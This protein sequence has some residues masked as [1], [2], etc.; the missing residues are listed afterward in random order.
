MLVKA[1]GRARYAY[2][3]WT[4]FSN[5]GDEAIREAISGVLAGAHHLDVPVN[6]TQLLRTISAGELLPLQGRRLVLG[7]GTIIGRSNWRRMVRVAR[8]LTSRLPAL[9]IG[10]GVEDPSFQGLN[11]FS[12]GGELAKW[13]EPLRHFDEICVRGPRSASLLRGVGIDATVVGDP[14]LLLAPTGPPAAP[15]ALVITLGYGDDLLG[16]DQASVVDAVV[17]AVRSYADEGVVVRFVVVAPRDSAWAEECCGRIRGAE[18]VAVKRP[19]EWFTAVADARVVVAQR[20]HAAVL[21]AGAGVPVVAL[22]YQPK[23]DDFM[24]SIGQEARCLSTDRLQPDKLVELIDATWGDNDQV[25]S[26]LAARVDVLRGRLLARADR[27]RAT[28]GLPE[29][30]ALVAVSGEPSR[31][32]SGLNSAFEVFPRDG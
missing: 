20:L 1:R 30:A 18:V 3:G 15:D 27:M 6:R 10:A 29:G 2:L 28:L 31:R 5:L 9:M 11:S 24:E 13:V 25:R 19:G 21:A 4:G 12:G 22:A 14:A 23:V 8:I 7:G 32:E 17:E 16:G 26:E